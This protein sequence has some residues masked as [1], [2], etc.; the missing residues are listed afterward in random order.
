MFPASFALL[1][2]L[3]LLAP[4]AVAETSLG[5]RC[6]ARQMKLSGNL[7]RGQLH[8]AARALL[9]LDRLAASANPDQAFASAEADLNACLTDAEQRLLVSWARLAERADPELG[10]CAAAH[11]AWPVV[12]DAFEQLMEVA[13]AAVEPLSVEVL[14]E[15]VGDAEQEIRAI[16][17]ARLR[18]AMRHVRVLSRTHAAFIREQNFERLDRLL[19]RA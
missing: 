15:A 9:D 16:T 14:A 11:R 18:V 4:Q 13:D 6:Q 17:R 1:A 3:L 5:S 8:C 2:L 19:E 7:L 10:P 12:E